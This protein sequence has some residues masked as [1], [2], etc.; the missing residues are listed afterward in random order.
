MGLVLW[1]IVSR[2]QIAASA[3]QTCVHDGQVLIGQGEVY[4]QLWLVLVEQSLQLL[5]VVRVH[6]CR[7]HHGQRLAFRILSLAP[8]FFPLLLYCL[9]YLVAFLLASA[10]NNK[11]CEH[12]GILR[13]LVCSHR[14]HASCSNHQYSAHS[15]SLFLLFLFSFVSFYGK[16]GIPEH[17]SLFAVLVFCHRVPVS[18]QPVYSCHS[19]VKLYRYKVTLFSAISKGKSFKKL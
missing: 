19:D 6:L 17:V 1:L 16:P 3:C 14:C 10:C 2:V 11:L 12:V 15:L 4:H 18:V 5:H 7:L 13:Y 8:C 9:H